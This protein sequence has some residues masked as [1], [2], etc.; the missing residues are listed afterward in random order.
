LLSNDDRLAAWRRLGVT[1]DPYCYI[2][3]AARILY[4]GANVSIG[5]GSIV[6]ERCELHA[7]EPIAIGSRVFVSAG[8]ML[9]TGS[10]DINSA[11][12]AGERA[13][14]TIGDLAWVALDALIL[15]GVSVGEGAVVAA[16]AVVPRDVPPYAVVA[17]NPARVVGERSR[18]DFTYVPADWKLNAT[19]QK[20]IGIGS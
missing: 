17:G 12:F 14:I 19:W 6:A 7:W 5:Y 15:P 9:L 10:H 13:P 8:A 2:D 16:R 20:H 4:N 18:R 3:P 1:C 11:D